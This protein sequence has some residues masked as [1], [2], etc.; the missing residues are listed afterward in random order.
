MTVRF[1]Y[2]PS[3][4][5]TVTVQ[6]PDRPGELLADSASLTF[7]PE[8]YDTPQTEVFMRLVGSYPD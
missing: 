3:S 5:V 6:S 8:N 1:R 7:T 2:P 4:D